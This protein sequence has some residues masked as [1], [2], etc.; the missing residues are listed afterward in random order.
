MERSAQTNRGTKQQKKFN[1]SQIFHMNFELLL[2][3][4]LNPLESLLSDNKITNLPQ[5]ILDKHKIIHRNTK[6]LKRLIDELMDFRKMQFSE[7]KIRVQEVDL[8]ETISNITS[9]F[10][11]EAK[12]RK[13]DFQIN[14][15]KSIPKKIWIDTSMFDK[16][17]FN[18]LSNAFKA[19]N[20]NVKIKAKFHIINRVIFPLIDENTPG[21]F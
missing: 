4:I 5:E 15:S 13:I 3:L 17:L 20:E 19:T 11:E 9:H 8:M 14:F 2:T 16:I 7:L 1:F 10:K 21:R 6:R 12:Y 18:L